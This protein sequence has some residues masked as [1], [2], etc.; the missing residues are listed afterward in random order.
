M[1]QILVENFSKIFWSEK[2]SNFFEL[3]KEIFFSELRFFFGYSFDVKFSDLSIYDVFRAFGARQ[4]LFPA[5]TRH[6]EDAKT[7][8]ISRIFHDFPAG[9]VWDPNNTPHFWVRPPNFRSIDF[10]RFWSNKFL[11]KNSIKVCT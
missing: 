2:F 4:T 8:S 10:R 1:C 11:V 7:C 5:P 6:C 3:G 9:T